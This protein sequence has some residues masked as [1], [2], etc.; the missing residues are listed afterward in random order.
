MPSVG[1]STFHITNIQYEVL[2]V[3]AFV[4]EAHYVLCKV[5]GETSDECVHETLIMQGLW[6][7]GAEA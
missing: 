3:V 7:L 4:M 1:C 5:K 2:I 6:S